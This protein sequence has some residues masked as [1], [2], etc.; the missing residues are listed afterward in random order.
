MRDVF[1]ESQSETPQFAT[2]NFPTHQQ[3]ENN[4]G[5]VYHVELEKL[6][7]NMRDNIGFGFFKTHEHPERGWML[8]NYPIKMLRGTE[9]KI[10]D[11]ED[12]ITPGIQKVFTDTSY[13]TAKTMKD[14]EKLVF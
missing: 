8:N 14:M 13:N 10:N 7:T 11:K 3:I 1:K 5:V 2:E 12:N 4:E 6:F 9:V